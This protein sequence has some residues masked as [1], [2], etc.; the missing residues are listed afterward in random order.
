M[1]QILPN[2]DAPVRGDNAPTAVVPVEPTLTRKGSTPCRDLHRISA[3]LNPLNP[4]APAAV[5]KF[6]ISRND[7][8]SCI[9]IGRQRCRSN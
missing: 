7:V 3:P 5:S 1:G 9:R 4:Y 8:D 6:L 2:E